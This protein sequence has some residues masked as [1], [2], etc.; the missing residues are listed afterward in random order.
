MRPALVVVDAPPFDDLT[1][2]GDRREHVVARR[3]TR[4][5]GVLVSTPTAWEPQLLARADATIASLGT[6]VSAFALS[7][8][9]LNTRSW[10]G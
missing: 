5:H 7:G 10:M 4:E 3:K 9:K 1:S 8:P 6:D 2:F